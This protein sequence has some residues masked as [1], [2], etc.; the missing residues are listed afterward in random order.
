VVR[1]LRNDAI[2]RNGKWATTRASTIADIRKN[3]LHGLGYQLTPIGGAKRKLSTLNQQ[4][5][6]AQRKGRFIPVAHYTKVNGNPKKNG[7]GHK[8]Y[9]IIDPHSKKVGPYV[10][11]PKHDFG[12]LEGGF[13]SN[14][15]VN[16][17]TQV[18]NDGVVGFEGQLDDALA[19]AASAIG[20][21]SANAGTI[22]DD[23]EKEDEDMSEEEGANTHR[24]GGSLPGQPELIPAV[25][26]VEI[27]EDGQS[28]LVHDFAFLL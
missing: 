20:N 21:I 14:Q 19:A 27:V 3:V 4:G 2:F 9:K 8:I 22:C 5:I 13:V 7:K 26:P 28:D 24:T 1:K 16:D 25:E 15:F 11:V 17:E 10:F 12:V 23:L 6:A 18:A